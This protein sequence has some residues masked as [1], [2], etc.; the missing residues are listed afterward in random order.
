MKVKEL[1]EKLRAHD[2][3]AEVG[4]SYPSHD[5]W[6]RELVATKFNVEESTVVYTAYHD[7]LKLIDADEET[8]DGEYWDAN[9]DSTEPKPMV[10]IL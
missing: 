2:P 6:G 4:K 7:T 10:V 5:H 1:I 3:E 9:G 8:G